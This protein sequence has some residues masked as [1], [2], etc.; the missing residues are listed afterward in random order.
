L[1]LELAVTDR[2]AT[3]LARDALGRS[4][5]RL[6]KRSKRLRHADA[7]ARHRVRVAAKKLRYAA[8]FFAPLFRHAGAGDY[9]ETLAELQGALGSL[10]DMAA[11]T[12]LLDELMTAASDAELAHAAGIVRG[13]A[14]AMSARELEQL[15]KSWRRFSKAKPF[16]D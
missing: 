11:A 5:R 7:A 9:I 10:N 6:S 16:W 3:A 1:G 15:P 13:W 8:E 4:A 2:P 12:R 14:A